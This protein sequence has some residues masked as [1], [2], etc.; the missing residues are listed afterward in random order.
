MAGRH[1]SVH[2]LRLPRPSRLYQILVA[3][4]PHG[5]V[6]TPTL[7][8]PYHHHGHPSKAHI[9]ILSPKLATAVP[10]LGSRRRACRTMDYFITTTSSSAGSL[11]QPH[12]PFCHPPLACRKLQAVLPSR[13][14]ALIVF[15]NGA[16]RLAAKRRINSSR[17]LGANPHDSLL[18][19][20][21]HRA[22]R[23]P[24][25]PPSSPSGLLR[26]MYSHTATLGATSTGPYQMGNSTFSSTA[27]TQLPRVRHSAFA[28]SL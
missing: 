23:P 24:N 9:S 1:R 5:Q 14:F 16:Q 13:S 2:T 26:H 22:A 21:Q 12:R 6:S 8:Q 11:H 15:L 17:M 27:P 20:P 18:S 28:H 10:S 19:V 7:V 25:L 4:V 3:Q